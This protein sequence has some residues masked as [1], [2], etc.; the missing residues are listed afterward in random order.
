M[1]RQNI[2][3]GKVNIYLGSLI[4]FSSHGAPASPLNYHTMFGRC[5]FQTIVIDNKEIQYFQS[6]ILIFFCLAIFY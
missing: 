4:F 5:K 2:L 1:C 6:Y 3:F